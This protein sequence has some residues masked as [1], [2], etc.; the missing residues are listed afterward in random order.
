LALSRHRCFGNV[1]FAPDAV[2]QRALGVL[3]RPRCQT[4]LR[5]AS[6]TRSQSGAPHRGA[7]GPR[8]PNCGPRAALIQR[9][10]SCSAKAETNGRGASANL[11]TRQRRAIPGWRSAARS[12]TPGD[13]DLAAMKRPPSTSPR[14]Q[15]R[16]RRPFLHSTLAKLWSF[17]EVFVPSMQIATSFANAA[18]SR[19]REMTL[20]ASPASR[21][22]MDRA[23]SA[24][25]P[26]W[27][28]AEHA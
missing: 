9:A 5:R 8:Q 16:P 20:F 24:G 27:Y 4:E 1:R 7:A 13:I 14:S 28:K 21:R 10:D 23:T 25:F 15:W 12:K 26:L 3:P 6:P 22:R 18:T 11:A 19:R 17:D 2:I